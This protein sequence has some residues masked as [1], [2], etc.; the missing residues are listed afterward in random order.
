MTNRIITISDSGVVTIPSRVSMRDFEIAQLLGVIVPTV[1]AKIKSL[2]KSR[3]ILDCSG[4]EVSDNT[5]I[6]EY[7]G[8]E[9]VTAIAFQLDSYEANVFRLH[10]LSRVTAPTTPP[11]YISCNDNKSTIYS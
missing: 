4:G 8:L 5:I 6:P 3:M 2:L 1:K 11:I 10:I 9:V 7:F